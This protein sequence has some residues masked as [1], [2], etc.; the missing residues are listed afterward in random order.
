MEVHRALLNL[1]LDVFVLPMTC[2]T[3]LYHDQL[4]SKTIRGEELESLACRYLPMHPVCFC[5]GPILQM[6][7]GR[8]VLLGK[9][10]LATLP[11]SATDVSQTL[12]VVAMDLLGE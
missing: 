11:R 12:K 4:C 6:L 5:L 7:T 2:C 1:C 8:V 9:Q 10:E 3:S